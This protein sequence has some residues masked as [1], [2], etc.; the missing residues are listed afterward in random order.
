MQALKAT[1]GLGLNDSFLHV[2]KEV[3][4]EVFELEMKKEFHSVLKL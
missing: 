4:F 2:T 1:K 3:Q